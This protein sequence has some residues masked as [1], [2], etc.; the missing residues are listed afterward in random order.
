VASDACRRNPVGIEHIA[1]I[2]GLRA[3]TSLVICYGSEEYSSRRGGDGHAT[4]PIYWKAMVLRN[5]AF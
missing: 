2:H 5:D 4:M 1:I 3:S